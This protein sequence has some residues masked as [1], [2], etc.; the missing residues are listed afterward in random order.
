MSPNGNNQSVDEMRSP[1]HD[2]DMTVSHGI[3]ASR[4]K[5]YAHPRLPCAAAAIPSGEQDRP[6]ARATF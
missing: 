2:I 6:A 1:A 5:A 4:I 3:E